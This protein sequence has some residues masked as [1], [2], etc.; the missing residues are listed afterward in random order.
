MGIL[1]VIV[2]L[3]L[4]AAGLVLLLPA[5]SLGAIR[6][7]AVAAALLVFAL[8]WGLLGDFDRAATG[9]Q[10]A[11]RA[12]WVPE[13]GMTYAL[14]VDGISLPM[15]L[16]TTL[17]T[18][19]AL[20]ASF[21]VVDRVKP[22]FAWFLVLET[23]MLG[24]FTAQDWF[25][26]YMFY[27][28]A[29]LPMFFLIG[30]WGG[31][32]RAAAA[33]SFLLYTLCG[34][35]LM[36]IGLIAAYLATPEHSFDMATMARAGAG[37][38]AAFQTVAF[39]ACFIGFA[40]KVP[41][42][43]LHGWLPLAHVE[44]PVPVS[45]VLSA[46]LLKMG[47]YG[48]LRMAELFPLGFEW[49]SPTLLVLGLINIVYGALMAWRQ[50]DLK[51]MVAFSSISHMGFVLV[52][53]SALTSAGFTGAM[54]QMFAHGLIAAALF[55]LVGF[56]YERTH[57]RDVTEFGGLYRQLPRYSLLMTTALLASMGLPG[58]AGFVAEFHSLV[59]AFERWGMVIVVAC[60]G[61]LVTAAYSLRTISLMF[62]GPSNPRWSALPDLSARE[63]AAA[64]PLLTMIVAFGLFPASALSLMANAAKPLAA[65]FR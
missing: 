57:T 27:E 24:V 65:L 35:V 21:S 47:A 23:A 14:G 44:A 10:F 50:S 43:P 13:M 36:L 22:Y 8:T 33:M 49:F 38:S 6:G 4:A 34:S 61:V 42:F 1:S 20:L 41:A 39:A 60:L 58:L 16:L 15:V 59:G 46:V 63:M 51:A 54:M 11:E 19:L 45:M 37:W 31:K 28:I 2:W 52:G 62:T 12:A 25:L 53:L 26:F 40:V 9:A 5:R 64:V 32:D 17:I 56:L 48:L 55:M 30:L 18:L 29:L 7:V 3:P